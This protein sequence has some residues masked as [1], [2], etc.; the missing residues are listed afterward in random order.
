MAE[1]LRNLFSK[2]EWLKKHMHMKINEIVVMY[3][4]KDETDPAYPKFHWPVVEPKYS[5]FSDISKKYRFM[6]R[7]GGRVAASRYCCFC[8]SCCL[9]LDGAEGSMTPLLEIP[10][11]RRCHLS[12]FKGSEQKITCTAAAGLANQKTR[13]K[14]LWAELKR[15]LK[16][17]KH[18]AIQARELWSTEVPALENSNRGL[19]FSLVPWLGL[20]LSS[21]PCGRSGA[22]CD[23]A[24]FGV[25]SWAML[26]A[27]A[28]PSF[29]PSPRRMSPLR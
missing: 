17:G 8:E 9:A 10:G 12:T 2:P 4:D 3:I 28:H 18:V 7:G 14:V 25:L 26:V 13:A 21:W 20:S 19:S 11:C 27:R 6:M 29:I 1:H 24:T 22:I 15:V 5:T 23:R 16:A